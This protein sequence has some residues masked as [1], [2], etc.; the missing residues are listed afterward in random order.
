MKKLFLLTIASLGFC[1]LVNSETVEASSAVPEIDETQVQGAEIITENGEQYAL[2]ELVEY[3]PA[4]GIRPRLT[5]WG[6]QGYCK[7][8]LGSGYIAW[9]VG[10]SETTMLSFSGTL[11]V[12]QTGGGYYRA[13][14]VS[15]SSG[16]VSCPSIRGTA[17]L[18]GT[19]R[20]AN[21]KTYY[22]VPN[23]LPI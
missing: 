19:A 12:A 13:T 6:T 23:S 14:P 20:G 7:L 2:I 4:T 21:G 15:G 18:S 17:S 22:T 16:T 9:G 8:N 3:N 5:F 11:T 1:F 10:L